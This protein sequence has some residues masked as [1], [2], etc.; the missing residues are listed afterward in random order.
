MK[1]TLLTALLCCLLLAGCGEPKVPAEVTVPTLAEPVI[2][3][4]APTETPTE[5]PTEASAETEIPET[6]GVP[7][8]PEEQARLDFYT[9]FWEL[10]PDETD[11]WLAANPEYFENGYWGIAVNRAGLADRG[12]DL[13]TKEG[14]QVLAVDAENRILIIRAILNNSRAVMAI[15]KDASRLH[16]CPA[17]ELGRVGEKIGSIASRNNGVLAITGS[18]FVDP[19]GNGNGGRIAGYCMCGTD[20]EAGEHFGWNYARF[21]LREDNWALVTHADGP[22][23]AMTT[24]AMEFEP[25]LL[26]KG[27]YQ[28]PGIWTGEN[29]RACIGQTWRKEILMLGV[30]GRYD[31][32]P[33]CSV[34]EC[35][36]LMKSYGGTNAINADGGT[37]AIVWYLGQPIM[38][39]SNR[40]TPDGR[41]LP[42]AWVYTAET[43]ADAD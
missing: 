3:T 36:R 9:V 40:G 19:G 41:Y 23:S 26:I 37:T 39:C 15:A 11:A 10:D 35:A 18:S 31:D 22:C 16:L 21:E 1:R 42:N 5:A 25:A 17:K 13:Y 38:R 14:H 29:P 27:E 6:T 43:E 30:E 20:Y 24:D 2:T 32:S 33:G 12:L 8:T 28:D 4:E 7:L 34:L